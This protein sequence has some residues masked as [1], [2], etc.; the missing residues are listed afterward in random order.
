M[1]L[2][3]IIFLCL[4]PLF[5]LGVVGVNYLFEIIK[6]GNKDKIDLVAMDKETFEQGTIDPNLTFKNITLDKAL[7][8]KSVLEKN[9]KICY[10][11]ILSQEKVKKQRNR[12]QKENKNN[13]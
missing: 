11:T 7:F 3:F 9:G 8:L 2:E 6:I 13:V 10:I 12:K 4:L 1:V 5:A